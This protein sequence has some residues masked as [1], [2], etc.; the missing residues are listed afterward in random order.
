M[1]EKVQKYWFRAKKYGWGWGLPSAWQGWG[2]LGIFV[3]IVIAISMVIDP[4]NQLS[5]YIGSLTLSTAALVGVCFA[6]G[7]P[8][9]WSWRKSKEEGE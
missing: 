1:S 3:G 9:K 5:L 8:P 6:K 2:V 7:E 4:T